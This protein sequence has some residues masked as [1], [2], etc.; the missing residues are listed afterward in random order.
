MGAQR[1]HTSFCRL[2]GTAWLRAARRFVGITLSALPELDVLWAAVLRLRS[3]LAKPVSALV[4]D[5]PMRSVT[6]E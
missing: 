5:A 4:V 1:Q 2:A 3:W 6:N